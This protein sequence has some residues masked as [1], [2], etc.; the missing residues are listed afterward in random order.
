[1]NQTATEELQEAFAVLAGSDPDNCSYSEGYMK[2][3]AVFACKTC[4]QAGMEPAGVCL[5]CANNCHD[6]HE[7]FE[8]Y[9]KRNFRCDCGNQ[10]FND[11]TCK[12]CP[13]KDALN[14]RNVYNHNYFGRYCSCERPYPDEDDQVNEEMI[15]CI[16]CEDW[17]H[18]KHLDSPAVDCDALMELIC[19]R[20]MNQAPFLW[21]YAA[22]FAVSPLNKL[23][24]KQV[25][26]A[27]V[28]D[29]NGKSCLSPGQG[30]Q[31][32]EIM[33]PGHQTIHVLQ[34]K[35]K[36]ILKELNAKEMKK[37]KK[38]A[39]FWPYYWRAELCTCTSCKRLYV[40]TGVSFLLDESDTLLAYEEKAKNEVLTC[41]NMLLS[42]ISSLD[43]VQQLEMI[44]RYNDLKQELGELLQQSAD[45]KKDVTPEVFQELLEEL[46]T[47]KRR[48]LSSEADYS[49]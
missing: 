22:Q 24:S 38:A 46:Q 30:S 15:Q 8:L 34:N 36:C 26:A 18:A 39:V 28:G 10:K 7:I 6:G 21:T 37:M 13:G 11:F 25:S 47:R 12:L 43:H 48:R 4:T 16:V 5:A 33:T 31:I 41:D 45:K 3:Q 9:T 1:M 19:V 17:Y 42:C 20:C 35:A 44:Y 23:S 40:E 14:V 32:D 29:E 49:S 27:F 2:R